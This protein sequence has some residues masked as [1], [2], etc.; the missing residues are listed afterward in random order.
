MKD[1]L[2]RSGRLVLKSTSLLRWKCKIDAAHRL[3]GYQGK[4][5]R[6]HGHTWTIEYVWEITGPLDPETGI[7]VDFA[8]L[9]KLFFPHQLD[10]TILNDV[11]QTKTR[12]WSPSAENLAT[13]VY[14]WALSRSRG[15]PLKLV[16]VTVW[17]T[18]HAGVTVTC[19]SAS[20]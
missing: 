15:L 2:I 16:E 19:P 4:C 14:K 1:L 12:I 10:H 5:A 20:G 6:L 11:F 7:S 8:R 18:E 13:Y 17:E 9:K 3:P